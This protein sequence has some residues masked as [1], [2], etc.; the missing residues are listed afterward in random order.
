MV[1]QAEHPFVPSTRLAA[2]IRHQIGWQVDDLQVQVS[3]S[4]LVLSGHAYTALARTW[5]EVEAARLGG[6]PVVENRIGVH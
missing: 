3:A 6:M 2:L 4:G 5:A 1:R